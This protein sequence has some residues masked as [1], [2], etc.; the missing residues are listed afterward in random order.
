MMH[1]VTNP[2]RDISILANDIALTSPEGFWS[3][4]GRLANA[5]YFNAYQNTRFDPEVGKPDEKADRGIRRRSYLNNAF[6]KISETW[7]EFVTVSDVCVGPDNGSNNHVEMKMGKYVVTHHHLSGYKT[8][9]AQSK[10]LLQNFE[11]NDE[12]EQM[13]LIP[14]REYVPEK[15]FQKPF[16]LL[17]LHREDPESPGEVGVIELVF[18]NENNRLATFSI[19]EI[20]AIQV[21]ISEMAPEE[22]FDF[23][24]RHEEEKRNRKA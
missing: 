20:V 18:A 23:K 12:L 7:P 24:F 14:L 3:E 1:F 16:N 6:R 10:Y 9:P 22:L 15:E 5:S 17:V 19:S 8:L 11:L 4:F 13:E 2:D 21:R